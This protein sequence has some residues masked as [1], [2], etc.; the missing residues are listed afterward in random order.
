METAIQPVEQVGLL[1]SMQDA[2]KIAGCGVKFLISACNHP[3]HFRRLKHK[4]IGSHYRTTR[5]W[6]SDW[7]NRN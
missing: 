6:L 2:A 3:N 4:R 5:E 1:I 7:L